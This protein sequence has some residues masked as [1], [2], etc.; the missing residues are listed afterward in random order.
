MLNNLFQMAERI[1]RHTNL[2][3]YDVLNVMAP[4]P[5]LYHAGGYSS[6]SWDT[7]PSWS[8]FCN[9]SDKL[10]HTKLC[11]QVQM[12]NFA[13]NSAFLINSEAI[14][15][16]DG[17]VKTWGQIHSYEKIVDRM[18]YEKGKH[19]TF[20]IADIFPEIWQDMMSQHDDEEEEIIEFHA[21][22]KTVNS[23]YA[24]QYWEA[25]LSNPLDKIPIFGWVYVG[26]D[27]EF[28]SVTETDV[29][30][31]NYHLCL[32]SD[33]K[34]VFDKIV[35]ELEP[36]KFDKGVYTFPDEMLDKI[37]NNTTGKY[38][39]CNN[40]KVIDYIDIPDTSFYYDVYFKIITKS[41][42]LLKSLVAHIIERLQGINEFEDFSNK[43]KNEPVYKM[44]CLDE[45]K[46]WT[47]W[48]WRVCGP[49]NKVKTFISRLND[50]QRKIVPMKPKSQLS[51]KEYEKE[52]KKPTKENQQEVAYMFMMYNLLSK[53]FC[54]FLEKIQKSEHVLWEW[55][56]GKH[57][58]SVTDHYTF[59]WK[60]KK[61]C[62]KNDM[63]NEMSVKL[64]YIQTCKY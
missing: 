19:T 55:P 29:E 64:E 13:A 5:K 7:F 53:D 14:N 9:C 48:Q 58:Q 36:E 44:I 43:I 3:L 41:I 46:E 25:K 10:N 24:N 27:E 59:S 34:D 63:Y 56:S 20:Y 52:F 60:D 17:Q 22:M 32:C 1:Q 4:L 11:Y 31:K 61:I 62:Y 42:P 18:L 21:P 8:K 15:P 49:K 26:S 23:Q 57:L 40:Q 6:L 54:M 30:Y 45:N 2:S 33:D 35:G 39:Y 38:A 37:I 16:C 50:T 28:I 12:E 47:D 51:I